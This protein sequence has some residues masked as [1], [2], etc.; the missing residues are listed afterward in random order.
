MMI[1]TQAFARSFSQC[2]LAPART[3]P[4][5]PD[6]SILV[7]TGV[8]ALE[9]ESGQSHTVQVDHVQDT[10]TLAPQVLLHGSMCK[11]RLGDHGERVGTQKLLKQRTQRLNSLGTCLFPPMSHL[12]P[13]GS[14]H[15]PHIHIA[16]SFTVSH[17]EEIQG[18]YETPLLMLKL[19]IRNPHAIFRTLQGKRL[20][21]P[22]PV[23]AMLSDGGTGTTFRAWR[24]VHTLARLSNK[25]IAP[26]WRSG[27]VTECNRGL[28][29][30]LD[31]V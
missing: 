4:M 11:V 25:N 3:D 19:G 24:G 13:S 6:S 15:P 20:C 28:S 10:E 30:I 18:G 27:T 2:R 22:I 8:A 31:E 7:P 9:P 23:K 14:L 5:W 1:R 16:C 21:G 29:W 17:W 26:S 12:P